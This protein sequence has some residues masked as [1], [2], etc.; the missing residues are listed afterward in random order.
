[1]VLEINKIQLLGQINAELL[2]T[3]EGIGEGQGEVWFLNEEDFGFGVLVE[4][5]KGK[6][7]L[8]GNLG[9]QLLAAEQL[10]I[11]AFFD[12]KENSFVLMHFISR[13]AGKILI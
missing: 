3:L 5:L 9:G 10:G 1:M 2:G 11:E 12:A 4:I 13:K 7:L 6:R 8:L